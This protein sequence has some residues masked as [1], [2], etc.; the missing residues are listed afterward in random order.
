MRSSVKSKKSLKVR[1]INPSVAVVQMC[2]VKCFWCVIEH[3]QTIPGSYHVFTRKISS[4][5]IFVMRECVC[6]CLPHRI[7]FYNLHNS[8]YHIRFRD[9]HS[10]WKF[11]TSSTSCF[12]TMLW[13]H[14]WWNLIGFVHNFSQIQ[15][16]WQEW[17]EQCISET[18]SKKMCRCSA[19]FFANLREKTV[20]KPG[21]SISCKW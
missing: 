15:R 13:S 9:S 4:S 12:H 16:F 3:R 20:Q 1:E 11:F 7:F 5:S 2:Y 10:L 6:A 19:T 17:C 18:I 21:L 8:I 14:F